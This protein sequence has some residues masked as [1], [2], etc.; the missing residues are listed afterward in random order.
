MMDAVHGVVDIFYGFFL[1]KIIPSIPKIAGT[2]EFC[3]TPLNFFI[4]MF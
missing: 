3:K 2:S 1:R 4:I